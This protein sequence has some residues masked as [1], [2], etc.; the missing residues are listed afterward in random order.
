MKKV[1]ENK[2]R[3]DFDIL[4]D[5]FKK[6]IEI[7]TLSAFPMITIY[8]NPDDYPN[9]YVAR[10]FDI[11]PGDVQRTRYIMLGDDLEEI[12]LRIPEGLYRKNRCPEDDAKI[13][14]VWF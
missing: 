11:R 10:V 6:D 12:R 13:L 14:E 5:S 2:H 7:K 8:F 9:K 4:V 3:A 1:V